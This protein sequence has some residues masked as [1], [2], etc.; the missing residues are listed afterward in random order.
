MYPLSSL[1]PSHHSVLRRGSC[2][3]HSL[4]SRCVRDSTATPRQ[5]TRSDRWVH[6]RARVRY[7]TTSRLFPLIAC[8][9]ISNKRKNQ[10][11]RLGRRI[12]M[13]LQAADA[14]PCAICLDD[15]GRGQA[16][17]T[18]ECSHVIHHRCISASVAFGHRDCP[19]CKAAW[20]DLPATAVTRP[21]PPGAFD[22]DEP[23]VEQGYVE[24]PDHPV[25]AIKAHC[26]RPAV[27]RDASMGSFSV[28]VHAVAP[29]V[30][31]GTQ[32]APLDLVT[33]IDLSASMR[34]NKLRLVK[35][36]V[37]FVIDSLGPTD[38]LSVVTFSNDASRVVRRARM[39]PDGKA[40]ARRAVDALATGGGT[41]IG[42]GLRV[43]ARVLD[44]RRSRN[45]VTSVILLTD[46]R[47]GY[48]QHRHVDLVPL[49]F[50]AGSSRV[51]VHAF[52]FG[53]DHDAAAMHAVAEETRG[54]F[55][56]VENQ[57]AI[58]DSFAQCIGGLLSVAMQN[59]RIAMTCVHPGVRVLGIN[60]ETDR[61]AASVDVGELYADEERRFLVFVRVP[62]SQATEEV[63]RLMKV[64]CLYDDVVTG[65]SEAVAG[66]DA[67]VLRP[68]QVAEGD[69]AEVSIEVERERV[70]VTATEDM[71][72]ARAAAERG[73]HAEAAR[74]LESGKEAVRWSAPGMAGDP[75]CAVLEEELSDLGARVASRREYEQT[76][77]A[78]ML[79]GM[80]SHRQ[81]RALS[82]AV[83]EAELRRGRFR[84][85]RASSSNVFIVVA[86]AA[87]EEPVTTTPS[88]E[89]IPLEVDDHPRAG[90]SLEVYNY[91]RAGISLEHA[92]HAR[93]RHAGN[94]ALALRSITSRHDVRGNRCV[95][96]P[97][98]PRK[99]HRSNLIAQWTSER[100]AARQT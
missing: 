94:D 65:C 34:G 39:T 19:L 30:V 18:A 46:G 85:V 48:V 97:P 91:P 23:V 29:G 17:F 45:P 93:A 26:E 98:T 27:A 20:R 22:D 68:W 9:S 41:N 2:P 6:Y 25:V 36:A 42:E 69:D 79:A 80:S 58:Q 47:D 14:D 56:F 7:A 73:N 72:A 59:A 10:R 50:R 8:M 89:P 87:G 38:R 60:V 49:S 3:I 100:H 67:V 53:A 96:S 63:T 33:A 52:G 61:R 57:A 76:G 82:V 92:V 90:M 4:D 35:Q 86:G 62:T 24:A 75:T 12:V 11:N 51:P 64:W 74:I 16:I 99:R 84:R 40:S 77:R 71:A 15:V 13:E 28:L 1:S 44:D 81:Q 55:S 37:C 78:A 88:L 32:R 5:I 54:T 95:M 70:R 31:A 43:A 21:S 83:E 66:E